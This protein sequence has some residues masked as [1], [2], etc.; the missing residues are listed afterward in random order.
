M[1][2]KASGFLLGLCFIVLAVGT[3]VSAGTM[4]GSEDTVSVGQTVVTA[5]VSAEETPP[6]EEEITPPG[7]KPSGSEPSDPDSQDQGTQSGVQAKA[8]DTADTNTWEYMLL[9]CVFSGIVITAVKLRR[10]Y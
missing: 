2:L 9:L 1:R 5:H 6:A 10:L 7:Q 4:H 8:V 3:P